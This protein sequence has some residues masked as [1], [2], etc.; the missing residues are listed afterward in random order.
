MTDEEDFEVLKFLGAIPDPRVDRCKK[1]PLESIL[2]ISLV[3]MLCGADSAH[4][5]HNG[6]VP[7]DIYK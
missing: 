1:R 7:E 5:L 4:E 6:L 3:G 2:F